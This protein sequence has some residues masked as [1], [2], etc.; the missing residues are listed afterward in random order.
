MTRFIQHL[1]GPYHG[2]LAQDNKNGTSGSP[3]VIL[4]SIIQTYMHTFIY[5]SHSDS[6]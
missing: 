4:S 6:N 1:Q 5:T 3:S 2:S